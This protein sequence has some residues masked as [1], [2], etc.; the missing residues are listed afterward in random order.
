M[1]TVIKIFNHFYNLIKTLITSLIK[2]FN[3]FIKITNLICFK[4]QKN[5]QNTRTITMI[6]EFNV[7][8]IFK[9]ITK[10]AQA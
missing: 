8:F 7:T 2:F 3:N 1:K 5:P 6:T 9:L 4:E 10:V